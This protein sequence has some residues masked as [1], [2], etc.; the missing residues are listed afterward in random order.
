MPGNPITFRPETEEQH[1]Q[2]N[3]LCALKGETQSELIRRLLAAEWERWGEAA[4][5]MHRVTAQVREKAGLE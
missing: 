2:L 1:E 4:E 5:E 3:R